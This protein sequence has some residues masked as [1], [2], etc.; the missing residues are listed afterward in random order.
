MTPRKK[1]TDIVNDMA[2]LKRLWSNTQPAAD[3]NPVPRGSYECDLVNIAPDQSWR[4]TPRLKITLLIRAGNYAGRSIWHDAYL[5][6]AALPFTIRLLQKIGYLTSTR[7]GSAEGSW[8]RADLPLRLRDDKSEFN[9]LATGHWLRC[10]WRTHGTT[11]PEQPTHQPDDTCAAALA[12]SWAVDLETLTT[13]RLRRGMI[14]Q[15]AS[16]MGQT[17]G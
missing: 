7:S 6:D 10:P 4:G 13:T 11:I 17:R 2:G 12:A 5:T 16:A 15:P 14:T 8:S 1:L 9:E 3:P